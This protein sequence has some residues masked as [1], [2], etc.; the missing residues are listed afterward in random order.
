MNSSSIMSTK[1]RR[2]FFQVYPGEMMPLEFPSIQKSHLLLGV[3]KK[4]LVKNASSDC[5]ISHP[6]E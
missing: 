2:I 6:V 3:E 5:L 1:F 4:E